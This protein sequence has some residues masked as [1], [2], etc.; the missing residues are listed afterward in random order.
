MSTTPSSFYTTHLPF[1]HSFAL[2]LPIRSFLFIDWATRFLSLSNLRIMISSKIIGLIILLVPAISA[3]DDYKIKF[4]EITT[5]PSL[6]V[7]I[8]CVT[9]VYT[10]LQLRKIAYKELWK[11]KWRKF[12]NQKVGCIKTID[13]KQETVKPVPKGLFPNDAYYIRFRSMNKVVRGGFSRSDLIVVTNKG[14]ILGVMTLKDKTWQNC[15]TRADLGV[16][17]P[18]QYEDITR[19]Y[20]KR[21]SSP[22]SNNRAT[23]NA[24]YPD[25]SQD[26]KEIS[27]QPSLPRDPAPPTEPGTSGETSKE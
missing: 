17:R 15:P 7:G 26:N 20:P 27:R 19:K 22:M 14:M 1:I 3:A 25:D 4:N 6:K 21:G 16:Y 5:A 8:D 24:N 9:Q 18:E 10:P 13:F 23:S 11:A 12:C 2:V